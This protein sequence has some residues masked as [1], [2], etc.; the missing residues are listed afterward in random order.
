MTVI[1]HLPMIT[2]CCFPSTLVA[3]RT[4]GHTSDPGTTADCYK[5]SA[6]D[7]QQVNCRTALL[8]RQQ[9][10]QS[11]SHFQGARSWLQTQRI[12]RQPPKPRFQARHL[13]PR[14]GDGSVALCP[15]LRTRPCPRRGPSAG[16]G[17]RYSPQAPP[18]LPPR[19]TY[20][21][22]LRACFAAGT[23]A[24][25]PADPSQGAASL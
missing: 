3:S 5:I 16:A 12:A 23:A 8:H 17:Q 15:S 11:M 4:L 25:T 19:A 21:A 2:Y 14:L 9:L 6:T 10:N 22:G 1:F 24:P 7:D 13:I 20:P 18:W